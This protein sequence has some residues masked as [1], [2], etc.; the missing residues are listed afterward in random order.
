MR[1]LRLAVLAVVAILALPAAAQAGHRPLETAVKGPVQ[2]DGAVFNME[3]VGHNDIG[4]R[5]YNA[6]V[7]VHEQHAYVGSWG[8]SDWN[9]GGEQRFCPNDGVAVIDST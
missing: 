2:Q 1:H 7:W 6:D 4:G 9:D 8:F 3:V 5:G